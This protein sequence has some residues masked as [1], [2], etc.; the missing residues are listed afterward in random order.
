MCEG[1]GHALEGTHVRS[2]TGF[3]EHLLLGQ[4]VI[5]QRHIANNVFGHRGGRLV[6]FAVPRGCDH[7]IRLALGHHPTAV[8]VIKSDASK[9]GPY[10]SLALLNFAKDSF[11]APV[12]NFAS[13]RSDAA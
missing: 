6:I 13:S 10:L 3:P 11:M 1:H 9:S 12:H 2:D 5:F 4:R 7:I 8:R